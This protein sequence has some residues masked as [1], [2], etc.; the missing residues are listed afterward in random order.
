MRFLE[1]PITRDRLEK[2]HGPVLAVAAICLLPLL[3]FLAAGRALP[4]SIWAL[5][6]APV[7]VAAAVSVAL[8]AIGFIYGR[9]TIVSLTILCGADEVPIEAYFRVGSGRRILEKRN[10]AWKRDLKEAVLDYVNHAGYDAQAG[11][12]DVNAPRLV[13]SL[14]ERPQF[15]RQ[16]EAELGLRIEVIRVEGGEQ[17]IVIGEHGP[18]A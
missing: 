18:G 8:S 15:L 4:G 16:I 1:D 2:L 11:G 17:S 9:S 6:A 13:R 3:Y 10:A 14:L 5:L 12:A 7:V